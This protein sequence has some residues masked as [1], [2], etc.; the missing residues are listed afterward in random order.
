MAADKMKSPDGRRAWLR[1]VPDKISSWDF[2]K[3]P[4]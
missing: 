4:G 2:R 1:L 3:L